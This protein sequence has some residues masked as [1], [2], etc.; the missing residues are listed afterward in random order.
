[1]KVY[2]ATVW[3]R[4]SGRVAAELAPS[5]NGS[6]LF[7]DRRLEQ[8]DAAVGGWA[9]VTVTPDLAQWAAKQGMGAAR[10]TEG[11]ALKFPKLEGSLTLWRTDFARRLYAAWEKAKPPCRLEVFLECWR[12]Q[13]KARITERDRST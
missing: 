13:G 5:A 8:C 9:F 3:R 12:D 2:G 1:M 10:W 7:L 6:E 4:I 11:A